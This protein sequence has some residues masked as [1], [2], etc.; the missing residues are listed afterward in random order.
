MEYEMSEDTTI[1]NEY[2]LQPL[3]FARKRR[4]PRQNPEERPS[5][6]PRQNH[7]P[8]EDF[9]AELAQAQAAVLPE[10]S[11]RL[12]CIFNGICGNLALSK[13]LSV[14]EFIQAV[15]PTSNTPMLVLPIG[16]LAEE[17][18]TSTKGSDPMELRIKATNDKKEKITYS[19]TFVE[20]GV[21]PEPAHLMRHQIITAVLNAEFGPD[22]DLPPVGDVYG[23]GDVQPNA[24]QNSKQ[25]T[26]P[27]DSQQS[28]D[29]EFG[30]DDD[31]PSPNDFSAPDD[32]DR[33]QLQQQQLQEAL[34]RK[35]RKPKQ[36]AKPGDSQQTVE[37]EF[38]PDGDLP[39][40][41]DPNF[42][43]LVQ[44]QQNLQAQLGSLYG[45][46]DPQ[47]SAQK[48]EKSQN[49]KK[50]RKEKKY[51][52]VDAS[53]KPYMCAN[54]G[55]RW[56]QSWGLDYHL[57]KSNSPCNP[58][59]DM[60][61]YEEKRAR[62]EARH[63]SKKSNGAIKSGSLDDPQLS[64]H[65]QVGE[66]GPSNTSLDNEVR[67]ED[68][69]PQ[70]DSPSASEDILPQD[71]PLPPETPKPKRRQPSKKQAAS[72]S[73]QRE[74][75]VSETEEPRT[76]RSGQRRRQSERKSKQAT[77][78]QC[79]EAEQSD[80]SASSD[81]SI[82]EWAQKYST[83]GVERPRKGRVVNDLTTTPSNKKMYKALPFE[84]FALGELVDQMAMHNSMSKMIAGVPALEG[85]EEVTE[86]SAIRHCEEILLSVVQGNDGF[87]PG[88]MAIWIGFV[89]IWVKTFGFAMPRNDVLPESKLCSKTVDHLIETKR[90]RCV[91]FTWIDSKKREITRTIL[92]LV[93]SQV[94][95]KAIDA[96]KALIQQ[97]YPDLYVPPQFAPPEPFL[98]RLNALATRRLPQAERD[99]L[100]RKEEGAA[101]SD[102]DPPPQMIGDESDDDFV[103]GEAE[104]ADE[105]ADEDA[106]SMGDELDNEGNWQDDDLDLDSDEK[107]P[108]RK[109]KRKGEKRGDGRARQRSP[110]HNKAISEGLRRNW[111]T[112]KAKNPDSFFPKRK[113]RNVVKKLLTEE[114]KAQ[115]AETAYLNKRSWDAQPAF[116]PNPATGAWDQETEQKKSRK[117]VRHIPK[118]KIP[119]PITYMQAEDGTWSLQPY[120]HGAPPI[121]ARPLRRMDEGAYVKRAHRDHRPV[122]FPK[123]NRMFLPANPPK[124]LLEQNL[125]TPAPYSG[126]ISRITGKPKRKYA[127]KNQPAKKPT[128]A[129]RTLSKVT[130]KTVRPY[131]RK[132]PTFVP[133]NSKDTKKRTKKPINEANILR[134]FEPKKLL[135][136]APRNVGLE[137]LPPT[138][139]L[140]ASSYKGPS[141]GVHQFQPDYR[142][143]IFIAPS[144]VTGGEDPHRGSWTV[145][146]WRPVASGSLTLT[147][148]DATAFDLESLPFDKLDFGRDDHYRSI[149]QPAKRR[150]GKP[151]PTFTLIPP[152]KLTKGMRFK[153]TRALTALPSDFKDLFD[154]AKDATKEL[155]VQI[156]Q[157]NR[158][159]QF[160]RRIKGSKAILSPRDEKRLILTVATIRT[161]T[162]GVTALIDWV[163]VSQS[164]QDYTCNFL[165]K[166]WNGLQRSRRDVIERLIEDFQK[167]FLQAYQKNKVP[168]IDYDRLTEY[169]F[170]Q[171]VKWALRNKNINTSMTT[172]QNKIRES[173]NLIEGKFSVTEVSPEAN[174]RPWRDQFDSE[175][176]A[177]YKKMDM[178]VAEPRSVLSM[179]KES[180]KMSKDELQVIRSWVRAVAVTPAEDYDAKIA[181]EKLLSIINGENINIQKEKIKHVLTIL[182]EQKILLRASRVRRLFGCVFEVT[183]KFLEPLNKMDVQVEQVI[184]A[185]MAKWYLDQRFWLDEPV[186]HNYFTTAGWMLAVTSMQAMGDIHT[187]TKVW[188]SQGKKMGML[189]GGGYETRQIPKE[190]YRFDL[191]LSPREGF[192]VYDCDNETLKK[193][194]EAE[195]PRGSAAGELPIWWGITGKLNRDIWKRTLCSIASLMKTRSGI[196]IEGLKQHFGYTFEEWELRLVMEWGTELGLFYG[197]YPKQIEGWRLGFWWWLLLGRL[198]DDGVAVGKGK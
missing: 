118:P 180:P 95:S 167:A 194:L 152:K 2:P 145:G 6:K 97:C 103:V 44:Q 84:S 193:F 197:S 37:D 100:R 87:F 3:V 30:P 192:Y 164:F 127:R 101:S 153:Y 13:D 11:T 112:R 68:G 176:T 154:D 186:P 185:A 157:P 108:K 53:D 28:V 60:T 148:N 94:D 7:Q 73:L 155:G 21:E 24:A 122:I 104:E 162:G 58:N 171:L 69:D 16:K 184:D 160:N 132:F 62:R 109:T 174:E 42:A 85:M 22:D 134:F 17:P 98:S 135:P 65:Q 188:P 86:S 74:P 81:D 8:D 116:M 166:Y 196:N 75:Q 43:Q 31:L 133:D 130:G 79:E 149:K 150:G 158:A 82:F 96:L 128:A 143:L 189:D 90:L 140:P 25:S 50:T 36:S 182:Q 136:G 114:E 41:D 179:P 110:T 89:G 161:L 138:F 117:G 80:A 64:A 20:T 172:K 10:G 93:G 126:S 5:Q 47:P 32:L 102:P 67:V 27:G 14:L 72:A 55:K 12:A 190:S 173:R 146:L 106:D 88:D 34:A 77:R 99:R 51:E 141:P 52:K 165:A 15:Q 187:N 124:A 57:T 183:G 111:A 26:K 63:G 107:K 144:I 169:Q 151:R 66:G 83:T 40:L 115:R 198:F 1:N 191:F 170:H 178:A 4:M 113:S 137:F 147:W 76:E 131:Q 121:H 54:C 38:G 91:D 129:C 9:A 35:S 139:G 46:G 156:G 71:I 61:A 70:V 78:A 48:P 56:M 125:L 45:S 168:K 175:K 142:H 177:L 49:P 33:V 23:S 123:K 92:I 163:L 119:Y 195:P 59:A 18:I 120:G 159:A 19:F 105:D 39:T 181:Q 29:D